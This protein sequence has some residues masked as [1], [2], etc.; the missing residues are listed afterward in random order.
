[1]LRT[2]LLARLLLV[3]APAL[4]AGCDR[5]HPSG[6]RSSGSSRGA[7]PMPARSIQLQQPPFKPHGGPASPASSAMA[8]APADRAYPVC[9]MD[10]RSW[11]AETSGGPHAVAQ[12]YV[13][14]AAGAAGCMAPTDPRL[15]RVLLSPTYGRGS[16]VY[17]GP[18]AQRDEP[19]AASW[20]CYNVGYMGMGRP[21]LSGNSPRLADLLLRPW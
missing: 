11:P 6:K 20:C 14:P 13:L 4:S 15:P 2:E 9:G 19:S 12:C 21:L 5:L 18:H 10:Y 1:M 7:T 16:C 8:P 3:A 17:D